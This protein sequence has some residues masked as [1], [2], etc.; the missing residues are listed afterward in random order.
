MYDIRGLAVVALSLAQSVLPS[1]HR[2]PI[3][4]IVSRNG[5]ATDFPVGFRL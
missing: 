3:G 2:K 1:T 4:F 5:R